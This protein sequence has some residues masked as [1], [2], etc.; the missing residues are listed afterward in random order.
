MNPS[1]SSI[2]QNLLMTSDFF[3]V[4]TSPDFFS[5]MAIESLSTVLPRWHAWS[6][7]AK[8]NSILKSAAYPYP[9][10]T[11]KFLGTVIQ[12]FRP[13]KGA[14]TVGFQKWIDQ[15][16]A[17]VSGRLVPTLEPIGMLLPISAY[18]KVSELFPSYCLAQIADFNTSDHKISGSHDSC[19]CVDSRSTR[20]RRYSFR[21]R[22]GKASGIQ[23]SLL[24]VGQ[25]CGNAYG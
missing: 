16:N 17:R 15:I 6:E 9:A 4:P 2:N 8:Q 18:Q 22:S 25:G 23:G 3:L 5:V 13:R 14:P 19:L 24:R 12:K 11:P 7:R 20:T 1:L 21:G 10:S